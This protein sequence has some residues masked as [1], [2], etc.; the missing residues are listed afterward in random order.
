MPVISTFSCSHSF[1]TNPIPRVFEAQD[2]KVMCRIKDRV[3]TPYFQVFSGKLQL[4]YYLA[5]SAPIWLNTCI[6]YC[7]PLND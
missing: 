1:K 2:C 7:L 4:V 6:T 3:R 5:V